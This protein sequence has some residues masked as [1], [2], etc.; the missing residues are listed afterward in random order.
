MRGPHCSP[1]RLTSYDGDIVARITQTLEDVARCPHCGIASPQLIQRWHS[2]QHTPHAI[3]P[4]NIWA[5]YSCTRCGGVV[6]VK[7]AD[8]DGVNNPPVVAVF[9]PAKEAHADIPDLQEGFFSR[10]MKHFTHRM[11]LPSWQAARLTAC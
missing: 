4:G 1:F 3:G 7:G 9:P 5:V 2:Q 6:T 11:P 8:G 10:P